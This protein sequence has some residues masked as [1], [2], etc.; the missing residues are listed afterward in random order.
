LPGDLNGDGSVNASDL[1]SLL[2]AWGTAGGDV[3]GDGTTDAADMAALLN[4]WTG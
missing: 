2:G 1:A 3:N 4:A